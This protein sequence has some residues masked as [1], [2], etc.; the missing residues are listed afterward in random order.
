MTIN[1]HHQSNH[2]PAIQ[3]EAISIDETVSLTAQM[4]GDLAPYLSY[5]VA[6]HEAL[7]KAHL[8]GAVPDI[9][10]SMRTA[11]R[12]IESVD[13]STEA[14]AVVHSGMVFVAALKAGIRAEDAGVLATNVICNILGLKDLL[15]EPATSY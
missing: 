14:V 5:G 10:R 13:P 8:I 4:L 7:L 2:P 12:H 11:A 3:P 15:R 1:R 6:Q 9:E